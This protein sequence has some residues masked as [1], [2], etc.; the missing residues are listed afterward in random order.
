MN[1]NKARMIVYQR[2]MRRINNGHHKRSHYQR[3]R[4]WAF[5]QFFR[6]GT[7]WKWL[8]ITFCLSGQIVVMQNVDDGVVLFIPKAD[9]KL[10]LWVEE[11]FY[12]S[13]VLKLTDFMFCRDRHQH[14]ATPGVHQFYYKKL[15]DVEFTYEDAKIFISKLMMAADN[16]VNFQGSSTRF[17]WDGKPLRR[18]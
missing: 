4:M 11:V 10:L 3:T 13:Y 14:G 18:R 15:R 2:R 5:R 16:E 8:E 9:T 7:G 17:T 12:H 6:L 1:P